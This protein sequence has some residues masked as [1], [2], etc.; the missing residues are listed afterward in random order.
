MRHFVHSYFGRLGFYFVVLLLASGCQH[1]RHLDQAQQ[2]FSQGAELENQSRFSGNT[3]SP[4]PSP[5]YHYTRSYGHLNKA[6]RGSGKKKLIEDHVYGHALTIK[7]LCEWKM[8]QYQQAINTANQA[9]RAFIREGQQGFQSP[10]DLAIMQALPSIIAIDTIGKHWAAFQSRPAAEM[11]D[12]CQT[13]YTTY[14]FDPSEQVAVIEG[15]IAKLDG[16]KTELSGPDLDNYIIL[17]QLSGLKTWSDGLDQLSEAGKPLGE[18]LAQK[19][20]F[21]NPLRDQLLDGLSNTEEG[22]RMRAYWEDRL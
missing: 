1:L 14:L 11:L 7:S 6:I 10:R 18:M 8:G 9:K 21:L 16:F 17:V 5:V 12:S 20:Q 3:A 4:G 13:F 2:A 22:Q 19:Q 15:A